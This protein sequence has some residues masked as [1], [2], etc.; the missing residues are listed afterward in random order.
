MNDI[1]P[2]PAL[3]PDRTYPADFVRDQSAFWNM[4][5]ELL[6]K[7]EGQYVVIHKE[8]VVASSSDKITALVSA[9]KKLGYVPVYAHRVSREPEPVS[10]SGVLRGAN[11]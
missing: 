10:H 8:T 5:D 3:I 9:Y 6:K 1:M 4:F 2:A 7:Y 11:P